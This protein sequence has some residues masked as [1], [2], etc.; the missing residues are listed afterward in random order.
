MIPI[1]EALALY[2][3]RQRRETLG[4]FKVGR[5]PPADRSIDMG[6]VISTSED[7]RE[8]YIGRQLQAMKACNLVEKMTADQ[9]DQLRAQAR[10]QRFTLLES[11]RWKSRHPRT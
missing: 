11:Q 10:E 4:T 7:V 2:Y 5:P 8:E 6:S 1:E 9:W 3:L